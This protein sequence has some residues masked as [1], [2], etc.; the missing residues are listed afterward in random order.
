MRFCSA[1][2]PGAFITILRLGLAPLAQ[3]VV[4]VEMRNVI[5]ATT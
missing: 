1:A 3:Q 4:K 2:G 5:N